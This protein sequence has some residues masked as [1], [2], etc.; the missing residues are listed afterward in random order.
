[1]SLCQSCKK[2][3]QCKQLCSRVEKQASRGWGY[4]QELILK[5]PFHKQGKSL[6]SPEFIKSQ[7]GIKF[8]SSQYFQDLD[9]SKLAKYYHEQP[10]TGR[11]RRASKRIIIFTLLSRGLSRKEVSQI[12]E[13]SNDCLR[14]HIRFIKAKFHDFPY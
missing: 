14:S 2:R 12:L 13:I 10:K 6:S 9:F 5:G 3:D 4:T 7:F 11:P 8:N 1:M